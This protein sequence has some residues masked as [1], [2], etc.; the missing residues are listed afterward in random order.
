M[1]CMTNELNANLIAFNELADYIKRPGADKLLEWIDSTD[2][3]TAPAS[4]GHHD[5]EIGGLL[6]HSLNVTNIML[7]L[8]HKIPAKIPVESIYVCG[9]FHD[10]CKVDSYKIEKRWRK[11]S[12]DQWEQYDKW[13]FNEDLKYGAHGAKSVYLLQNFIHLTPEEASAINAHMG[14]W[15][16]SVYSNPGAVYSWN[17]LAW[18]LHVADEFDTYRNG[19]SYV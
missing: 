4:T 6:K 16:K 14:A 5:S 2:Y 3:Y 9:L 11:N 1:D 17:P 10:L 7:A 19:W 13:V 18:L 15:D 12:D 8:E